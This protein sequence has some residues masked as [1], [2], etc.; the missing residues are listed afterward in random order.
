MGY[1][2]NLIWT[3]VFKAL[4]TRN[5]RAVAPVHMPLASDLAAG[6]VYDR[7]VSLADDAIYRF[8]PRLAFPPTRAKNAVAR[9]LDAGFVRAM[10]LLGLR[11]AFELWVVRRVAAR[12]DGQGPL[13]VH[14]D[15]RV[16]SYAARQDRRRTYWKRHARAADAMLE[17]LGGG[18]ADDSCEMFFSAAEEAG[19]DSLLAQV[20]IDGPFV[21]FEPETN[22]DYFGD[23]RAWP[24]ENWEATM[25]RLAAAHPKLRLVQVGAATS[26]PAIAGAVDLRGKTSF[27][28]ACLVL[29]RAR[30]FIGTESGL[31]HAA[32]AVGARALILWGGLTLP[33]FIGY[34]QRQRTLCKYVACAPCG[35]NGWC[36]NGRICMTR[37]GVDEALD[38]ANAML[39]AT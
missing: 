30:L 5:A 29:K 26:V 20:G 15:M 34:P 10:S 12:D 8:N 18:T 9:L 35:N 22:R 7:S 16:H 21:A 27:R 19:A 13:F 36:D 6:A 38:A 37:I 28:A 11:R 2:G 17:H 31:M 14:V 1:G 23:L 3:T 39:E 25:A 4:N 24:R 32:N 33:E